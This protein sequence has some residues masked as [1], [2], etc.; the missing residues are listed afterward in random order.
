MTRWPVN[1][2]PIASVF[3]TIS[4][5]KICSHTQELHR[6][7]Y[8]CLFLFVLSLNCVMILYSSFSSFLK[9]LFP[10]WTHVPSSSLNCQVFPPPLNVYSFSLCNYS[11]FSLKRISQKWQETFKKPHGSNNLSLPS[12]NCFL[13][14]EFLFGESQYFGHLNLWQV[15]A[16][17][18][19]QQPIKGINSDMPKWV[20][21]H[22][23]SKLDRTLVLYSLI[24][25]NYFP[26]LYS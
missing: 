4:P 15:K 7:S 3:L 1:E 8:P 5:F 26:K 23:K 20:L 6:M 16:S 19:T 14:N 10:Q 2:V 25:K 11:C 13:L 18:T 24:Y 9:C 22:V 12:F 17:R 21:I